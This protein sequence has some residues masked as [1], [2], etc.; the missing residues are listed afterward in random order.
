[1]DQQNDSISIAYAF[2]IAGIF[3]VI[4]GLLQW[5][6]LRRQGM[7]IGWWLASNL[8]GS[9]LFIALGFPANAA[10]QAGNNPPTLLMMILFGLGTALG[11]A[12]GATTGSTLLWNLQHP[13]SEPRTDTAGQSAQ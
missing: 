7:G 11:L 10:I 12:L 3:G 5:L 13:M 4:G 6:V 9:F 8:S 1:M 2:L